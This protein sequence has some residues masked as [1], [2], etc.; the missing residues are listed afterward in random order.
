MGLNKSRRLKNYAFHRKQIKIILGIKHP[1]KISN[2]K[3]CEKKPMKSLFQYCLN[4]KMGAIWAYI[5]TRPGDPSKPTYY[6]TQTNNK[7][8]RGKNISVET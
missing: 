6:F 5:K 4:S 1:T 2:R 3:L 8:F 7:G